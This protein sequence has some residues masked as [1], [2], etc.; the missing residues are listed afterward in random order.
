[1][2]YKKLVLRI[3][4]ATGLNFDE[5]KNEET[6]NFEWKYKCMLGNKCQMFLIDNI[7]ISYVKKKSAR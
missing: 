3:I 1:M 2:S 6:M 4:F 5:L 7:D